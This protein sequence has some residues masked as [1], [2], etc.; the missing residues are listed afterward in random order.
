MKLRLNRLPN[1]THGAI[2]M[3]YFHE[4]RWGRVVIADYLNTL[5]YL[6]FVTDTDETALQEMMKRLPYASVATMKFTPLHSL[7]MQA[8]N[9][10]DV[11]FGMTIW[12]TDFQWKIWNVLIQIPCGE[13]RTYAQVAE[14]AGHNR[15]FRAVGRAVG[16]NPIACFIPCH[17]V[18]RSDGLLG[19]YHWGIEI[20][21][22]LLK[23][24]KIEYGRT[25]RKS[26]EFV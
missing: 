14:W 6:G 18:V 11:T 19:G 23:S 16:E 12:A 13:T 4:T 10:A 7:V 24:E 15:A 2:L 26:C 3:Y 25:N 20:K 5:C 22:L 17:R 1:D 8:L 9:G 21:K